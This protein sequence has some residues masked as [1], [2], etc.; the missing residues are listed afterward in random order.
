MTTGAAIE[1]DQKTEIIIDTI[2]ELQERWEWLKHE[3]IDEL[4]VTE[5]FGRTPEKTFIVEGLS[6]EIEKEYVVCYDFSEFNSNLFSHFSGLIMFLRESLTSIKLIPITSGYVE[7][8]EFG[9]DGTI[10]ISKVH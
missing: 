7:Q 1:P 6:M 9:C 3:G 8:L 4:L 5:K 2:E 10:L